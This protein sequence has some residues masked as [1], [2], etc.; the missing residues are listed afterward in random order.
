MNISSFRLGTIALSAVTLSVLVFAPPAQ[1]CLSCGCGGSGSSADLGAIGGA[2]SLFSSGKHWLIQTGATY[3]QVNGSFN[4]RGTWHTAPADSL[5]QSYQAVL[6][7]NYFPD[8]QWTIGLQIPFQSNGLSGASWGS[9]GS[10]APNDLPLQYG[11]GVGDIQ[12]QGAYKFGE[13]LT[14]GWAAWSSLSLPS[15]RVDTA[16]PA[17]TTGSGVGAL[18]GG[19]LGV[20]KPAASFQQ[21]APRDFWDWWNSRNAEYLINIG[22]SQALN[23]PPS[24]ISPFFQGQSLM[25]QL[26]ANLSLFPQWTVG[27]GLNG[28]I[29]LW[30]AGNSTQ[31]NQTAEMPLQWSS[32]WRVVPSVQ[33]ELSMTQGVRLATGVDLPLLG[34]NSLTDVSAHLVY[35]QFFE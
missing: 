5:M 23:A 34:S 26:Q 9:F 29:G 7:V 6:G 22:Y 15:G 13:T 21:S 1:A 31:S 35:Y 4:E 2:S 30:S 33:Y 14:T 10:I 12:V 25:T 17:N 11:G 8:D 27:L 18:A 19:I 32:R 20:Y 24:Q 28:Q 16:T 3:R